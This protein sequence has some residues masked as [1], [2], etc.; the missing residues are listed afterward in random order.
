MK[1]ARVGHLCTVQY[2]IS[3]GQFNVKYAFLPSLSSVF[4]CRAGSGYTNG[5]PVLGNSRGGFPLPSLQFEI[6]YCDRI[7]LLLGTVCLR[8]PPSATFLFL[9]VFPYPQ[10][11]DAGGCR[12]APAV[13]QSLTSADPTQC[14]KFGIDRLIAQ[15]TFL[16][17]HGHTLTCTHTHTH[18]RH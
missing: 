12:S 16:L 17:E 10:S 15:D 7:F 5:Y 9:R 6:T 3:Q 1:A 8:H 14:T 2:L 11:G 13:C 4:C 18:G